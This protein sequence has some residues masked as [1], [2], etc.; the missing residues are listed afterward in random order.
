MGEIRTTSLFLFLK[1]SLQFMNLI[2][3]FIFSYKCF[4]IS[5]ISFIV[6][7]KFVLDISVEIIFSKD[8]KYFSKILQN[9]TNFDNH[10]R[11]AAIPAKFYENRGENDGFK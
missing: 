10:L 4:L 3:L 7:S 8:L 1:K 2:C 11:F 6:N 5:N 9:T